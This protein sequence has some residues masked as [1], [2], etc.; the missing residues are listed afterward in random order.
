MLDDKIRRFKLG[1]KISD[2]AFHDYLRPDKAKYPSVIHETRIDGINENTDSW[3]GFGYLTAL[4]F[5]SV[6]HPNA[7]YKLFIKKK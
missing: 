4:V 3:E 7:F 2:E 6:K 1:Y 5:N